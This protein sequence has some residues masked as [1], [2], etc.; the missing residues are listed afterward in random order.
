MMAF[1]FWL[2]QMGLCCSNGLLARRLQELHTLG[3]QCH[4]VGRTANLIFPVDPTHAMAYA[5][6]SAITSTHIATPAFAYYLNDMP[7]HVLLVQVAPPPRHS[8]S[9]LAQPGGR[10]GALGLGRRRGLPG[11][12]AAAEAGAWLGGRSRSVRS[13]MSVLSFASLPDAVVAARV[14]E[15]GAEGDDEPQGRRAHGLNQQ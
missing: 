8:A 14:S 11:R 2:K 15:S 4:P 3:T 1:A 13:V 5:T 6:A 10:T 7:Y 12:V 9:G